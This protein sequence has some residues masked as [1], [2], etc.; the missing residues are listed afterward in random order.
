MSMQQWCDRSMPG[1]PIFVYDVIRADYIFVRGFRRVDGFAIVFFPNLPHWSIVMLSQEEHV[2]HVP[3]VYFG[4]VPLDSQDI[5]WHFDQ[6]TP[7]ALHKQSLG[8]A[9]RCTSRCH[10][11]GERF[12]SAPSVGFGK[13]GISLG[14]QLVVIAHKSPYSRGRQDHLH[15]RELNHVVAEEPEDCW[16]IGNVDLSS[17]QYVTLTK[18]RLSVYCVLPDYRRRIFGFSVATI[19]SAINACLKFKTSRRVG[20]LET[21]PS[22]P[23]PHMP[24]LRL[25]EFPS[26]REQIVQYLYGETT[27]QYLTRVS[28]LFLRQ[29]RETVGHVLTMLK[30]FYILGFH[31]LSSTQWLMVSGVSL[32]HAYVFIRLRRHSAMPRL[33]LGR[34]WLP[35]SL[36][37]LP[38]STE[39][40][41]RTAMGT[42]P[43][44]CRNLLKRA[45]AE[46]DHPI[47]VDPI[48]VERWIDNVTTAVGT[49]P[50]P[51]LGSGVCHS[52]MKK[53]KLKKLRCADCRALELPPCDL[54]YFGMVP[55][56]YPLVEQHPLIPSNM[57]FRTHNSRHSSFSWEGVSLTS[58]TE[59]MAIYDANRPILRSRGVLCGPMWCGVV[60]RC[61]PSN[62]ETTLVAAA[63]R[64]AVF[65]TNNP[66]P[67]FWKNMLTML[68]V[69]LPAKQL[70]PVT[71]TEVL[72]NQRSA[73]RRKK[74]EECFKLIDEGFPIHRAVRKGMTMGAFSKLEKHCPVTLKRGFWTIKPKLAPRLINNPKALL[75]A[76][77]SVYT[78]PILD[79]LHTTWS[80]TSNVFYAGCSSP[81]D[82][83]VFLATAS[84]N[85]YVLEDD[86]SMMD[87]SHTESSQDFFRSAVLRCFSGRHREILM[88]LLE[89]CQ[90]L[91]VVK[92]KLKLDITGPNPSGVPVTSLLNSIT[93]AFVRVCALYFAYTGEDPTL[94][95]DL[96]PFKHF[97]G[98]IYCA[99]AGDDGC[100]FLPAQILGTDT[101]SPD[102][103]ARYIHYFSLSG[104]DVGPSKIRIHRPF[105]WRLHTFLAMRPY[106]SGERYEYGVEIS[107]RMKAMFWMLDKNHHPLAWGRGVALSLYKASRHVPV[108][109]DICKWYLSCTRGVTTSISIASFTNPYSSVYGYE[110]IGDINDRCVREFCIDYGVSK[111]LYDD[112]LVYLWSQTNPLINLDHPLL[113]AISQ[114]E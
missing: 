68:P 93:T 16:L 104:F 22:F 40:V 47:L 18:I 59:V 71:P 70:A 60:I 24:L 76:L 81:Q 44:A 36:T 80:S 110:V 17:V 43:L 42:D 13:R 12:Q 77:M 21:C 38:F 85:R 109:S 69:L 64:M 65:P 84:E 106:W 101:F 61:Y 94:L 97:L 31:S 37:G 4:N 15:F 83:N 111:D 39:L 105:Q 11:E 67:L 113:W 53:R 54:V 114:K 14:H 96:Q 55:A 98:L 6:P 91:R 45:L 46:Y 73:D 34:T 10:H 26:F 49:M 92:G 102:F 79:W 25:P 32:F 52:C 27:R 2:P 19:V 8:L 62:I 107:R 50:V 56:M 5:Y 100:V 23:R 108:I 90:H 48:E 103:M 66:Q 72:D 41:N 58:T 3:L 63:I 57:P 7:S 29:C 87:G 20:V 1:F 35:T 95:A 51:S 30:D 112:F 78:L 28:S 88:A 82:L 89:L 33:T 9:C 99:V 86:V 74:L 75:N